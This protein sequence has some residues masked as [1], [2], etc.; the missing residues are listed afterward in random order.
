M[1]NHSKGRD[2]PLFV[3]A[4]PAGVGKT[5]I[6]QNLRKIFPELRPTVTYT[7]RT[8]RRFG[9]EDKVVHYVD[10]SEFDRRRLA[11]E[12]IETAYIH[13]EWYGTHRAETEDVMSDFPVIMNIDVQGFAQIKKEYGERVIS[14]F[15]APESLEQLRA[16][17]VSRGDSDEANIQTRL[18][19][20]EM[21]LAHQDEFDYVV[22]NREGKMEE[23]LAKIKDIF[24][25]KLA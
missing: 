13:G 22:L 25:E 8:K 6:I 12:F 7:T 4:G 9:T 14:I 15:I 3:I 16:H 19:T 2:N 10:Q 20:A 21:E 23:T 18:K 24:T 5:T 11:G 17:M 1:K